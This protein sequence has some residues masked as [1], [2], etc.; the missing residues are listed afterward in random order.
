MEEAAIVKAILSVLSPLLYAQKKASQFYVIFKETFPI[1]CQFPLVQQ[2]I[3][4][5]EENRLKDALTEN[6]Q[7]KLFHSDHE[8]MNSAH[9]V[10]DHEIL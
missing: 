9:T 4:E 10:L 8:I 5:E 3:E 7:R 6:L 1:A 2:Y